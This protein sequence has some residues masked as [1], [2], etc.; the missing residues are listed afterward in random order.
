MAAAIIMDMATRPDFV[1]DIIRLLLK[2]PLGYM[3]CA[4]ILV[5]QRSMERLYPAHNRMADIVVE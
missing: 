3:L 1:E 2:H 4:E 5:I